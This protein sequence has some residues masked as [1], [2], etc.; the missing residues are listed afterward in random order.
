MAYFVH[1]DSGLEHK[2]TVMHI[3]SQ[4][5]GSRLL[6]KSAV[7]RL[8]PS[9]F[10]F[11]FYQLAYPVDT[12]L[13]RRRKVSQLKLCCSAP[14]SLALI[15]RFRVEY[16]AKAFNA[17]ML[18]LKL[19]QRKPNWDW[20]VLF[21]GNISKQWWSCGRPIIGI[22]MNTRAGDN[23]VVSILVKKK[24]KKTLEFKGTSY[25]AVWLQRTI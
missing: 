7:T 21:S 4:D 20:T 23:L 11:S 1:T 16:G 10:F 25:Q 5:Q 8:R 14:L 3:Q 24:K 15:S 13:G 22:F 17:E 9:L 19:S 12:A 2:S 6:V 18:Q